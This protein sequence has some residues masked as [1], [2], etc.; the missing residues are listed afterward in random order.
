MGTKVHQHSNGSYTAAFSLKGVPLRCQNFDLLAKFWSSLRKRLQAATGINLVA[1]FDIK[2]APIV[3]CLMI[4][5]RVNMYGTDYEEEEFLTRISRMQSE[6]SLYFD[7]FITALKRFRESKEFL[8]Y[9]KLSRNPKAQEFQFHK[10]T[11]SYLLQVGLKTLEDIKEKERKE[12]A[13]A[14]FEAKL[15]K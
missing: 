2:D 3:Y 4:P 5:S 10:V 1:T 6:L 8:E 13:R 12:R 15:K 9:I 14:K 11:D 7:N